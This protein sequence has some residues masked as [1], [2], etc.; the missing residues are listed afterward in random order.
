MV[1]AELAVGVPVICPVVGLIVKPAGSAGEIVQLLEA[2][3]LF[4]GVTAVIAVP[5]VA[6][7]VVGLTAILGGVGKFTVKVAVLDC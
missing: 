2:P 3:P 7:R 4:V 1:V 5:T 6:V